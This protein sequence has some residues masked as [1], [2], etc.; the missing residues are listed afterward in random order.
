MNA[1][2]F[3][4]SVSSELS[5]AGM[6]WPWVGGAVVG[7]QAQWLASTAQLSVLPFLQGHARFYHAPR[8]AAIAVPVEDYASRSARAGEDHII[9]NSYRLLSAASFK[10]C[11]SISCWRSAAYVF[12]TKSSRFVAPEPASTVTSPSTSNA[13]ASMACA[14]ARQIKRECFGSDRRSGCFIGN[15]SAWA[16]VDEVQSHDRKDHLHLS[17]EKFHVS[18]VALGK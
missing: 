16:G 1:R 8:G 3:A 14:S 11:S 13:R 12:D 18:N 2:R 4:L 9:R 7:R 10:R 15:L 5:F 17:K 6:I